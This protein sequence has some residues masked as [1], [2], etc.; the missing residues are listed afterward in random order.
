M[1]FQLTLL[2]FG[3][4][5]AGAFAAPTLDLMGVAKGM[6]TKISLNN[7]NNFDG[8]FAG[9]I[10]L[11]L[12][13]NSGSKNFNGFCTDADIHVAGS[14]WGVTI[15]NTNSLHP[16]GN[17]IG[18][19]VNTYLPAITAG[20]TNEQARALQLVIW[21]LSEETG[22]TF[23]LTSGHFQAKEMDGSQLNASTLNWANTYLNNLNS[24]VSLFYASDFNHDNR[25]LSQNMVAPVPEPASIGILAIGVLG[26]LKRRRK[27]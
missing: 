17:R 10:K 24:G 16:N 15:S 4:L 9:E 1:K 19:L 3:T 25:Q 23:S 27:N 14:A 2:L 8:V 26:L 18:N 22:P 20:G 7:G 5:A 13:T 12:T 21:E 11:K 6:N